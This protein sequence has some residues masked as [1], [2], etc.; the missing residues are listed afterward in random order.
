MESTGG[1]TSGFDYL[2]IF[3]AACVILA[4]SRAVTIGHK[5][6]V[7]AAMAASVSFPSPPT[8]TTDSLG[9]TP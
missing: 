2:R 1:R 4:H 7:T 6:I 9:N 8:R 3:L 5:K